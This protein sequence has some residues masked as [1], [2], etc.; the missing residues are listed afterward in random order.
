MIDD[1]STGLKIELRQFSKFL[2]SSAWFS[3]WCQVRSPAC[4]DRCVGLLPHPRHTPPQYPN[5]SCC[6][7][8]QVILNTVA[9]VI[10]FFTNA[11]VQPGGVTKNIL[12]N[13]Y[14]FAAGGLCL[15]AISIFWTWG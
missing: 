1:R 3:W 15:G 10:L 12:T 14:V 2:Q 8:P 5:P 6:L 7:Y 11:F 13:G 4:V 9:G